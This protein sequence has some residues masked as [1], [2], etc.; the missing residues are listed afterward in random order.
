[1]QEDIH[2]CVCVLQDG[3][4]AFLETSLRRAPI[5]KKQLCQRHE[6]QEKERGGA[7]GS[8]DKESSMW[9]GALAASA[10]AIG[11]ITAFTLKQAFS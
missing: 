3:Y 4:A 7:E 6:T 1:M 5:V 2:V 10:L 9:P 8:D 11:A